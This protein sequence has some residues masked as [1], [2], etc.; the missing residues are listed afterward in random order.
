MPRGVRDDGF[1]FR[2]SDARRQP[3]FT[4]TPPYRQLP[5]KDQPRVASIRRRYSV[6]IWRGAYSI[7]CFAW[8]LWGPLS[9]LKCAITSS[10][11][12]DCRFS[13]PLNLGPRAVQTAAATPRASAQLERSGMVSGAGSS[14]CH[15]ANEGSPFL[16][17]NLF[18]A[19]GAILWHGQGQWWPFE[20]TRAELGEHFGRSLM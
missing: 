5:L 3:S 18:T 8:S 6:S 16:S 17:C 12:G 20:P 2:M 1:G 7:Y 19:H 10:A 4:A 15:E 14:V 9:A 11:E 13:F